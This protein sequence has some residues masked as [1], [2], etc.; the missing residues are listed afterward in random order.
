MIA[1]SAEFTSTLHAFEDGAKALVKDG[2]AF[3]VTAVDGL[4]QGPAVLTN[5]I[6]DVGRNLSS[7]GFRQDLNN[8]FYVSSH[9]IMDDMDSLGSALLNG[10]TTVNN[11][12]ALIVNMKARA[13][14]VPGTMNTLANQV[15]AMRFITFN[16]TTWTIPGFPSSSRMRN[17]SMPSLNGL[18]DVKSFAS[19][20]EI[21][22]QL[23]GLA[24]DGRDLYYFYVD[25]MPNAA[26]SLIN[27][28]INPAA[29]LEGGITSANGTIQGLQAQSETIVSSISRLFADNVYPY[30]GYRHAYFVIQGLI[31]LGA[32]FLAVLGVAIKYRKLM[33]VLPCLAVILSILLWLQFTLFYAV[34]AP[35][36]IV[37]NSRGAV[38]N[39]D[40]R[41]SELQAVLP[42]APN[43][44]IA[45]NPQA[46]IDSCRQGRTVFSANINSGDD[47]VISFAVDLINT[48]IG[49]I[50]GFIDGS[51]DVIAFIN[52]ADP[53]GAL[54]NMN[55]DSLAN[56]NFSAFNF[57]PTNASRDVGDNL[58]DVNRT[59]ISLTPASFDPNRGN[60]TLMQQSLDSFN[61][62]SVL[63]N[64]T[65]NPFT[66][67]YIV[68]VY[69]LEGTTFSPFVVTSTTTNHAG[70]SQRFYDAYWRIVFIYQAETAIASQR[71]NATATINNIEN[72]RQSQIISLENDYVLLQT[73]LAGVQTLVN[74][75]RTGFNTLKLNVNAFMASLRAFAP[76]ITYWIKVAVR[77][78]IEGLL[79]KM[80]LNNP[81]E[82]FAHCQAVAEDVQYVLDGFCNNFINVLSGFW[83]DSMFLGIFLIFSF[84]ATMMTKKRAE[85]LEESGETMKEMFG[86]TGKTGK[87]DANG[88]NDGKVATRAIIKSKAMNDVD[89]PSAPPSYDPNGPVTLVNEQPSYFQPVSPELLQNQGQE[90]QNQLYDANTGGYSYDAN[91]GNPIQM[92]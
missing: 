58:M 12:D 82:K 83:Y 46:F 50:D 20:F 30:D 10:K 59:F 43:S 32:L 7:G 63:Q 64:G 51:F 56:F 39:R 86:K 77:Y 24:R 2:A 66:Y 84:I 9:T 14:A 65:F 45:V 52:Q 91:Q 90:Y 15:D 31:V 28:L 3:A 44:T 8:T 76:N 34:S 22:N 57:P 79:D 36:N 62:Y 92:I 33:L 11:T 42:S 81:V 23:K 60:Y 61:S 71:A 53:T 41:A 89:G 68:A 4:V 67:N 16:G 80:L 37:C 38:L 1:Y 19:Q 35:F 73:T 54:N 6:Q 55:L 75:V 88:M 70:I 5:V 29:L 13:A 47:T 25:D 78:L 21:G 49:V 27:T 48:N 87:K 74:N 26:K 18:P 17:I 85:W 40:Y 69:Y 72:V